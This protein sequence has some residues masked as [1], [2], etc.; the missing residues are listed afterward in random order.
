MC[1]RGDGHAYPVARSDDVEVH[2]VGAVQ[3]PLL[4]ASHAG[5]ALFCFFSFGTDLFLVG[6][7]NRKVLVILSPASV[8]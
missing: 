1:S 5:L 2:A 4:A 8:H 3:P 7:G 6:G